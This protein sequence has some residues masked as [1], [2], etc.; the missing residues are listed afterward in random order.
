MEGK[1]PAASAPVAFAFFSKPFSE[2]AK[3]RP[4]G[5]GPMRRGGEGRTPAAGFGCRGSRILHHRVEHF[6]L[7][8]ARHLALNTKRANTG[9]HPVGWPHG[10]FHPRSAAGIPAS[11]DGHSK[12]RIRD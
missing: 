3:L 5:C 8:T 10:L 6:R 9:M 12:A 1:L 11:T 7:S 2:V 4:L